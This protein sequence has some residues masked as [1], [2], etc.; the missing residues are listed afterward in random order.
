MSQNTAPAG[1]IDS[2]PTLSRQHAT[3]EHLPHNAHL[4]QDAAAPA[5]GIKTRPTPKLP[6]ADAAQRLRKAPGRPRS[7]RDTGHVPVTSSPRTRANSGLAAGAQDRESCVP[8]LLGVG[9]AAV[10]LS[11]SPWTIRDLVASGQ[12]RPV[13][14]NV[15]GR[16]LRRLLL[17][18][19]D[20]DHI[21]DAGRS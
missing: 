11:L 14:L 6:L 12:L 19:Q 4:P 8:R 1:R 17:D 7:T 18:R 10:Y 3:P 20:L 15:A 21:A 13:R 2:A 5:D 16:E 9:Q